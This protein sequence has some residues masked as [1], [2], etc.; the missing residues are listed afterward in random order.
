MREKKN[1]WSGAFVFYIIYQYIA[2][3]FE[4]CERTTPTSEIV[5]IESHYFEYGDLFL[6]AQGTDKQD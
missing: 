1:K 5:S 3:V 6:M 4:G 2:H